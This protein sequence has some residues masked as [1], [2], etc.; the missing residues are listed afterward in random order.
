MDAVMRPLPW[1]DNLQV[2]A[3]K[4]F[5]GRGLIAGEGVARDLVGKQG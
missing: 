3:G 1:N 2:L 4:Y 5:G